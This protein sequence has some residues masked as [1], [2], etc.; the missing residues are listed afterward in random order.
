MRLVL[1][2]ILRRDSPKVKMGVFAHSDRH[3]LIRAGGGWTPKPNQACITFLTFGRPGQ[4][5]PFWAPCDKAP[6]E[7][8]PLPTAQKLGLE[9]SLASMCEQVEMSFR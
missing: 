6:F 8:K 4:S 2:R 3:G 1:I 5:K 7:A 9:T